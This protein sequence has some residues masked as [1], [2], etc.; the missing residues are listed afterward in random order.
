M[1][2]AALALLL[3]LAAGWAAR[4]DEAD[5]VALETRWQRS[6]DP[7][8]GLHAVIA[9]RAAGRYAH[10]RVLLEDV[11]RKLPP[12]AGQLATRVALVGAR[13]DELT[14]TLHLGGVD[15]SATVHVDGK[16]P[17]QLG[18]QLVLDVGVRSIS[19][20]QPGCEPERFS[21]H[22]LPRARL[23]ETVALTCLH[24]EGHLQ[25]SLPAGAELLVDDELTPGAAAD[26]AL[27]PGPHRVEV[28]RGGVLLADE[29]IAILARQDHSL[30]VRPGYRSMRLGGFVGPLALMN[31]TASDA[32]YVGGGTA[33]LVAAAGPM[34][35]TLGV[36]L[37]DSVASA[38]PFDGATYFGVDAI[39][40]L[41][42]PLWQGRVGGWRTSFDVSPVAFQ[43]AYVGPLEQYFVAAALLSF[44]HP[45]SG[46]HAE[47]VLWPAGLAVYTDERKADHTEYTT[48]LALSLSWAAGL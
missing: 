34:W 44:D 39:V 19:V 37:G 22:V 10:A 8:E 42:A 4:A 24:S 46:V 26:V 40:S 12:A 7:E 38:G 5:A 28:R 25:V 29:S 45:A 13:L 6:G 14:G 21:L 48:A 47:V 33:G 20:D 15:A 11:R 30:G 18:D 9:W 1:T 2:R 31:V 16:A 32:G 23:D 43:L 35:L 36:S 3:V 27:A 41:A 17:A